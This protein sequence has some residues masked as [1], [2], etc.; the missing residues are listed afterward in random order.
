MQRTVRGQSIPASVLVHSG[1]LAAAS[2][3]C[4]AGEAFAAA[5]ASAVAVASCCHY[6]GLALALSSA[7]GHSGA[8]WPTSGRR[9]LAAALAARSA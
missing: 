2:T 7:S 5:A 6:A 9:A 3:D 1:L 8:A 4:R